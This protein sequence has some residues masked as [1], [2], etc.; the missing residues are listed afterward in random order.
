MV[1]ISGELV[2]FDSRLHFSLC[3]YS[4]IASHRAATQYIPGFY[5][6]AECGRASTGCARRKLDRA[7]TN[8]RIGESGSLVNHQLP[9]KNDSDTQRPRCRTVQTRLHPTARM[10]LCA[11]RV[12]SFLWERGLALARVCV[13]PGFPV[14]PLAVGFASRIAGYLGLLPLTDSP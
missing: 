4:C 1:V 6:P 13:R 5:I 2:G 10:S 8:H 7:T 14:P 12:A 11:T 3:I 9:L